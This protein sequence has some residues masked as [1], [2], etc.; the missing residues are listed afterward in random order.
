MAPEFFLFLLLLV[1]SVVG[2]NLT[3]SI[4]VSVC[5]ILTCKI[6]SNKTHVMQSASNPRTSL[7]TDFAC[8][9]LTTPHLAESLD[10]SGIAKG[11]II[12]AWENCNQIAFIRG[13]QTHMLSASCLNP[14][15]CPWAFQSVSLQIHIT[16]FNIN[17]SFSNLKSRLTSPLAYSIVL[18]EI[19]ALIRFQS[20]Q[21]ANHPISWRQ[22]YDH[23]LTCA[24]DLWSKYQYSR[25]QLNPVVWLVSSHNKK[26]NTYHWTNFIYENSSYQLLA[27][28]HNISI[29]TF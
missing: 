25:H 3:R 14:K 12:F 8:I 1:L 18:T 19:A 2:R 11:V 10:N 17:S 22:S 20:H 5:F 13:R 29:Q 6:T 26:V 24:W 15:P 4:S 9:N 27:T 23:S 16:P 21:N 28:S 7:H